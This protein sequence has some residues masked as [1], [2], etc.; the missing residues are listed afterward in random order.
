M[1]VATRSIFANSHYLAVWLAASNKS[2][3]ANPGDQQALNVHF[4]L[5]EIH[6]F[7]NTKSDSG[8]ASL[9]KRHQ[10]FSY[11]EEAAKTG[12]PRAMFLVG[13]C[14]VEGFGCAINSRLGNQLIEVSAVWRGCDLALAYIKLRLGLAYMY[15]DAGNNI[16][17]N[18]R[19]AVV[20]LLA[21]GS[22]S[23]PAFEVVKEHIRVQELR[24]AQRSPQKS[25]IQHEPAPVFH[26]PML[27]SAF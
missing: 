6:K 11:L 5:N 25:S 17:A 4:A 3:Q 18:L 16:K 7:F 24:L 21:A 1:S 9:E 10:I 23:Q 2:I 8:L 14:H 22:I 15:G 27:V 13:L 12:Y 26:R 20:H 19:K